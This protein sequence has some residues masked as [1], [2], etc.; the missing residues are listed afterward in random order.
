MTTDEHLRLTRNLLIL[1]KAAGL[2]Q[3]EL[4]AEIGLCRALYGQLEQGT[5]KPDI[6]VLYALSHYYHIT[7]DLLFTCD[8]QDVLENFFFRQDSSKEEARILM[9]YKRLSESSK[10][11]LLERAEEL[12]HLEILRKKQILRARR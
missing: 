9:L 8:I 12:S 6:N 3:K 5:R 10:G 2:S 4:S 1:R 7:L 11:Q